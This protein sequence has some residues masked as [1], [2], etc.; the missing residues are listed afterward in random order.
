MLPSSP[1]FSDAVTNL[2]V[3]NDK[4]VVLY[5]QNGFVAAAR[6]WW[7]F[8]LFGKSDVY[9]LN[10]GLH[11]WKQASFLTE[12]G[13]LQEV[14][15]PTKKFIA[16]E[17]PELVRNMSDMLKQ[18]E[19]GEGLI[20]DARSQA[21]FNATVPE[22][23]AGLMG[24]H[25]PGAFCLPSSACATD[26]RLKTIE[27]LQHVFSEHGL[28]PNVLKRTPISLT[29]GSGIT[30]AIVCLALYELGIQS[31]VYDGSWSEYGSYHDNPVH[32]IRSQ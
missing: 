28:T 27:E 21:R 17:Q 22:P 7:M 18:I 11:S 6:A 13:P 26:G 24:G 5:S 2:A 30:A 4:P 23:R 3:T 15:V 16:K 1:S 31:A 12:T 32:P 14:A 19:S 10:G 29:C 20:I 25:M 8:R 9:I